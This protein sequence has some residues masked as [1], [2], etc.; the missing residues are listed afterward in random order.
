MSK[1]TLKDL[2]LHLGV[3]KSN[4]EKWAMDYGRAV[5]LI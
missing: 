2:F 3:S 1:K 5:M 4:T